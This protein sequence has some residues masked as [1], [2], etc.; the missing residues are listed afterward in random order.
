MIRKIRIHLD[1]FNEFF[2]DGRHQ[3]FGLSNGI[4][5]GYGLFKVELDVDSVTFWFGPK[6]GEG[7]ID[8]SFPII[9]TYGADPRG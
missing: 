6:Q 4:P 3:A 2:Q 7:T 8:D 1:L 5:E 9:E